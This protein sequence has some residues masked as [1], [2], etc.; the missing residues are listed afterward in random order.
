MRV[1]GVLPHLGHGC[2]A[3]RWRAPPSRR[4][5]S[6]RA[7]IG[8]LMQSRTRWGHHGHWETHPRETMGLGPHFG[9]SNNRG[10]RFYWVAPGRRATCPRPQSCPHLFL[11]AP[12]D[13]RLVAMLLELAGEFEHVDRY[14]ADVQARDDSADANW[15]ATTLFDALSRSSASHS[16]AVQLAFFHPVRIRSY[17]V[18]CPCGVVP[19]YPGRATRQGPWD[20][21]ILVPRSAAPLSRLELNPTPRRSAHFL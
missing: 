7:Q 5:A 14:P 17:G 4:R 2:P 21:P 19:T 15:P 11:P 3:R 20:V 12:H 13:G 8:Y 9:L 10:C 16:A 18:I 1:L 6:C